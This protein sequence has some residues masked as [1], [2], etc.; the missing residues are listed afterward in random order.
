[1]VWRRLRNG[2]LDH[3][4]L[5]L[6]VSCVGAA[7]ALGWL[8]LALPLPACTLHTLTGFPCLGCG[9]TR[10]LRLLLGGEFS[11]AFA[12]NPLAFLTACG[13]VVFDAYAAAA[14]TLRLPRLRFDRLS[15]R[16]QNG[17]R[18]G[19]IAVAFANWVWLICAKV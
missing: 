5:W 1:M 11:A 13:F 3:E 8:K 10:C 17:A 9:S 6:C 2:E 12:M 18:C 14:L 4:L 15:V 16:A 19:V 7:L